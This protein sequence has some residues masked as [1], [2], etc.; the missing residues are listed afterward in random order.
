MYSMLYTMG[1]NWLWHCNIFTIEDI[2]M[3]RLLWLTF[4]YYAVLIWLMKATMRLSYLPMSVSHILYAAW[5]KKIVHP[6]QSLLHPNSFTSAISQPVT[7][8]PWQFSSISGW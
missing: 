7:S 1:I 3:V 8:L 2:Y 4:W 6:C 5:V